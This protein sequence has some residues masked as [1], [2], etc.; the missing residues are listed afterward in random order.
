ML[1][2]A[3]ISAGNRR[4]LPTEAVIGLKPCW[5]DCFQKLTKSG[6]M[7]TPLTRST[8]PDLNLEICGV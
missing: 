7:N 5:Y 3:S 2:M 8:P 4:A 1:P 6:G